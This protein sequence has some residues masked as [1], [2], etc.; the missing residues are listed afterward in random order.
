M[1]GL[2]LNHVSKRGHRALIVSELDHHQLKLLLF[3]TGTQYLFCVVLLGEKC[4]YEDVVGAAPTL[5]DAPT[6]SDVK[7][8]HRPVS[9]LL[10]QQNSLPT[11]VRLHYRFDGIS[12]R[13]Y[14]ITMAGKMITMITLKKVIQ[15]TLDI[16]DELKW[17]PVRS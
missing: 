14:V 9:A 12:S 7:L 4:W 6:T 8:E 11:N 17:R 2:K 15:Y 3:V 13:V 5:G 16:K 1:L 10:Q